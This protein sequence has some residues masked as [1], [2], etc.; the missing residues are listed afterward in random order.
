MDQD[1]AIE[2]FMAFTGKEAGDAHSYLDA[3]SWD[4][5]AAVELCFAA[6]EATGGRVQS[7]FNALASDPT[8][9]GGD[10]PQGGPEREVRQP[11][12]VVREQLVGS[13]LDEAV[14]RRG[15]G[16]LGGP[17]GE[18]DPFVGGL[19]AAARQP[20]AMH[21]DDEHDDESMELENDENSPQHGDNG[22][23][24]DDTLGTI[25][26]PPTDLTF[27]GSFE[28]A[29]TRARQLDKW[30]LANVQ[31]KGQLD[32]SEVLNRNPFFDSGALNRDTWS[33]DQVRQVL[34]GSFMLY[35]V[36]NADI[37]GNKICTYYSLSQAQLPAVLVIDP[38]TGALMKRLIGYVDPSKLLEEVLLPYMDQQPVNPKNEETATEAEGTPQSRNSSHCAT[39][40]GAASNK[41]EG[42]ES[43]GEA[44]L[45]CDEDKDQKLERLKREAEQ[46]LAT[47]PSKE[48]GGTLRV[49]I[50]LPEGERLSRRFKS[51]D[52][53]ADMKAFVQW[54]APKLAAGEGFTLAPSI[55]GKSP[56][57]KDAQTLEDAEVSGCMLLVTKK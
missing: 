36:Y 34:H 45:N 51:T 54:K 27:Q 52:T 18:T 41:E 1:A 8:D 4:V 47:E 50:K 32:T 31:A 55:P 46:K 6:D 30:L 44:M 7:D 38:L 56:L 13:H 57:D 15:F 17:H 14:N 16:A 26:R 53:V 11:D 42:G 37:E 28:S 29:K 35:Q 21:F 49:L 25:F 12:D 39:H 43:A 24:D 48:A 33:N 22:P 23:H 3:A 19:G 40:D 9:A 10:A 2:Q 5:E 20:N